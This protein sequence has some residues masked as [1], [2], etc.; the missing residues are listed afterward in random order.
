LAITRW[1]MWPLGLF[2]VLIVGIATAFQPYAALFSIVGI[3]VLAVELMREKKGWDL[4]TVINVMFIWLY[5]IVPIL[6][7]I[8]PEET[9]FFLPIDP[10]DYR[11]PFCI[12][13]VSYACI[14]LGFYAAKGSKGSKPAIEI[15][16]IEHRKLILLFFFL[17]IFGIA[18]LVGFGAVYGGVDKL[19]QNADRI[20]SGFLKSSSPLVFLR[21][22]STFLFSAV[23]IGIAMLI[24]PERFHSKIWRIG[25]GILLVLLGIL[26]ALS[27]AGRSQLLFL[28]LPM[29][30]GYYKWTGKRP[31]IGVLL[32]IGVLGVTIVV[33]GAQIFAAMHGEKS[34]KS[35]LGEDTGVFYA[36]TKEFVHPAGS[37]VVLVQEMPTTVKPNFFLDVPIGILQVAPEKL[38]GFALPATAAAYNTQL[39]LGVFT[40]TVPPGLVGFF[41]YSGMW[42]GVPIGGFLFGYLHGW[43]DRLL[44]DASRVHPIFGF[45]YASI[46]I[47]I[48][49]FMMGG[50]TR[51]YINLYLYS[52]WIGCIGCVALAVKKIRFRRFVPARERLLKGKG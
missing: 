29:I 10:R 14:L 15:Q 40:P 21:S 17:L 2:A 45:Y 27:T 5:S 19:I 41:Y 9:G 42:A 36:F 47:T 12:V 33:F 13:M 51:V 39:L 6:M 1:A 38:L 49:G 25:A 28:F 44:G 16:G 3:V 24:K 11:I 50:D 31:S 34:A 4:L 43:L 52:L 22:P 7:I 20:R 48:V 35:K 37:L 26:E 46:T 30:V 23:W 32:L 8:A 18:S